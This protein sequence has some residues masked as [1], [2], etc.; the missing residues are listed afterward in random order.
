MPPSI[1]SNLGAS[2]AHRWM[3]CPASVA[4]C[5]KAPKP[6]ASSHANEGTAAHEL[7]EMSIRQMKMPKAFIGQFVVVGEETFT[8]T[9][10][11]AEY[12]SQYV[13]EVIK[14]SS[15]KTNPGLVD[16]VR[17]ET[18]FNLDWIGRKGMFGT[19]DASLADTA[20]RKLYVL[21]LKY[22]SGVPV[23]A[24]NNV[25]L[26]YYALGIL[27]QEGDDRFDTVRLTIV[28][29]RCA[30]SGT[31]HWEIPV[32]EL[33]RFKDEVLIPAVDATLSDDAPFAPSE[34]AC[35]WCAGKAI[36]PAL[37]HGIAE[38]MNTSLA[39]PAEKVVEPV[40]PSPSSLTDEQI[41]KILK[42]M[43]L[44][45]PFFDSVA[46]Y[47]LD[48]AMHGVPIEGFKLV[49]GRRGNRA[50]SDEN[51]VKDTF[52]D[53]GDDLYTKKLLS[54][55]QL[56]KIVGKDAVEPL[57]VRPE[58]KMSLAPLSDKRPAVEPVCAGIVD[59]MIEQNIL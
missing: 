47:A 13:N 29:P 52:A 28:Q 8:V 38:S 58:A 23:F 34:K 22:G 5:A 49:K 20:H 18:R 27:G 40:L 7:A 56:E 9:P 2:S 14:I 48:R 16:K 55:A 21:D 35:H 11:M 4:L 3:T 43:P 41:G 42:L 6:K 1:H 12:V 44:V 36:C 37:G 24:E 26:Q 50:W 32:K 15:T 46:E 25:Q 57:T 54:P 19:C 30:E 10:D 53:L 33:L 31:T 39:L 45:K 17:V 59:S 51:L